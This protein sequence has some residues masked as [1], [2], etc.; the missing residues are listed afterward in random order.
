MGLLFKI[1]GIAALAGAALAVP[2]F[3]G[4]SA[5]VNAEEYYK[6]AVQLQAKGM[7]ALFDKR[8]KPMMA[9]MKDAGIN[10]RDANAAATK[11]GK[12]LYCVPPAAKKKG[13]NAEQVIRML[14]DLGQTRRQ[15]TTLEQAWLIALK[16]EYPC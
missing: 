6:T 15:Q 13:M 14:G 12:P 10:A 16:K 4:P 8:T 2:A 9:Q 3:A 7:T 5:N 1:T 11:R